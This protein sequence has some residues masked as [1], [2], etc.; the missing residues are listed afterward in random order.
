[1]LFT[2]V[3]REEKY[4]VRPFI[5]TVIYR[6]ADV[7][8]GFLFTGLLS[9]GVG[10]SGVSVVGAAVAVPWFLLA[11]YLGRTHRQRAG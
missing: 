3:G 10:L 1:V 5:D 6:G 9:L 8:G 2:V 11:L 7:V 4:K